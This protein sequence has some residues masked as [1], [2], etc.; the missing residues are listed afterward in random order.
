MV[1][2]KYHALGNDYFVLDPSSGELPD[3]KGI[4]LVCHRNFGLGSD[5][6]L[7][8]PL[9]S[10]VAD[11]RLRILNP[12]GSEAEK[13]GNGLR[14]FCRY[15]HDRGEVTDRPFTVETEGGVVS[16]CIHDASESIEVEMGKV[17]F[18]S[19]VI[20]VNGEEREVIQETLEAN[21]QKVEFSAATIGNPH[22]VVL[23]DKVSEQEA[24]DLG[25]HLENHPLFPNRTNVQFLE[26]IDRGNIRLE[27]WERGAGYT[28]AS[29]SSS[30]A[31]A[32][33]ARKLGLVDSDVTVHMPG[34]LLTLSISDDFAVR[35][36][37]PVR[38]IGEL[39]WTPED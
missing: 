7:Y 28:L 38:L 14:I 36:T 17:S 1:F 13:S 33:V 25:P 22:C 19:Q 11:F 37:G 10:E 23:R 20:P 3:S 6:I 15:L 8:G 30:S 5:G 24:R 31:A 29:G 34:G 12:D 18:S 32:S 39:T 2:Q 4:E 35:M 27:I 26:V 21:G 9:P 16:A